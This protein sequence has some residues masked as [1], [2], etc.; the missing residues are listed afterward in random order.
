MSFRSLRVWHPEFPFRKPGIAHSAEPESKMN[1][2]NPT[3][4]IFQMIIDDIVSAALFPHTL[5][6][7]SALFWVDQWYSIPGLALSS[8][9]SVSDSQEP[10]S[11]PVET[12]MCFFQRNKAVDGGAVCS[13]AGYDLI[14]GS[15]FEDNL[16]G[17]SP[18][19]VRFKLE[20]HWIDLFTPQGRLVPVQVPPKHY[21]LLCHVP[22]LRHLPL[23]SPPLNRDSLSCYCSRQWVRAGLLST[24]TF[25]WSL[26]MPPSSETER[27][28]LGWLFKVSE[29]PRIFS[30]PPSSRTHTTAH[31]DSTATSTRSV[32]PKT[33]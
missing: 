16:A 9:G 12:S 29:S 15:R 13:A 21:C 32:N 19:Q 33:R 24:P 28:M 11:G 31:L 27:V 5:A 3:L 8:S 25:W 6:P 20:Q 7:F 14:E 10:D 2:S 4:Q 23:P 18:G 22:M 26:T 30:T 1:T 17:M